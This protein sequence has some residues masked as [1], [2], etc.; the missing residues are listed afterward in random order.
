[1][2]PGRAGG[3]GGGVSRNR[4]LMWRS[5][6]PAAVWIIWREQNNRCFERKVSIKDSIIERIKIVVA[7]WMLILSYFRGIR[8][9]YFMFNWKKISPSSG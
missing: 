4:K 8:L 1:M 2:G 6:F 7:S 3:Q 9:D 5:T